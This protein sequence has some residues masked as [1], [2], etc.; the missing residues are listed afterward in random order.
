MWATSCTVICAYSDT[1]TSG[2]IKSF[3]QMLIDREFL[4]QNTNPFSHHPIHVALGYKWPVASVDTCKIFNCQ[5][6]SLALETI[7]DYMVFS[8]EAIHRF[9][10]PIFLNDEYENHPNWRIATRHDYKTSDSLYLPH[11]VG[12]TNVS[13]CTRYAKR[14]KHVHIIFCRY[15]PEI[16]KH[17]RDKVAV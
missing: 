4:H 15:S 10:K 11:I 3:R 2:R 1:F 16:S 5:K 7:T 13:R 6:A 8:L 14:M 17:I 12:W 9:P